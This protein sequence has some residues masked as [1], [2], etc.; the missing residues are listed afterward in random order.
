MLRI[1][2]NGPEP[3]VR[4]ANWVADHQTQ[5][6]CGQLKVAAALRA[7]PAAPWPQKQSKI[8]VPLS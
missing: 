3:K 7:E 1:A 4:E 6:N 2:K 5:G 8:E